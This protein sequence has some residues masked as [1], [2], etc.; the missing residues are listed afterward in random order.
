MA[1]N[2]ILKYLD[3]TVIFIFLIDIFQIQGMSS[4]QKGPENEKMVIGNR[5]HILKF[6]ANSLFVCYIYIGSLCFDF[7]VVECSIR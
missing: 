7:S 3:I 6:A 1:C 5:Q 2:I 4:D